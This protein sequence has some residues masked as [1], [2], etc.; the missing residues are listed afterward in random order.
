MVLVINGWFVPDLMPNYET[1]LL[2]YI[3]IKI[4]IRSINII[5]TYFHFIKIYIFTLANIYLFYIKVINLKLR[6]II[7]NMLVLRKSI[8]NSYLFVIL[9]NFYKN[10]PVSFKLQ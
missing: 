4:Y 8:V 7:F 2:F 3:I 10:V 1:K 5:Y 9:L 6:L